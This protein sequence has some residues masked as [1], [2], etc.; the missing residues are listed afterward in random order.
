MEVFDAMPIAALVGQRYLAL[1]GGISPSLAKLEDIDKPI[2]MKEPPFE[3]L[4]CDL[5]WADPSPDDEAHMMPD[6]SHNS[7]RD[8]S[9]FFGKQAANK[10]L[11]ANSLISIL[12]GHQVQQEGYKM[13]RFGDRSFSV[14]SKSSN[15]SSSLDFP[16]VVTIFSA[17]N[18]CGSYDNRGA[19]FLLDH[20]VVQ[21]NQFNE[22]EAPYKLPQGLDVFSWSTPFIADRIVNMFYNIVS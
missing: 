2:R 20:G 19:F 22:T 3:G 16:S 8:C 12:R 17:P 11:E 10:F 18:Y 7:D 1:H 21:M 4:L 14:S 13:H 6:F 15:A 9:V 5:M